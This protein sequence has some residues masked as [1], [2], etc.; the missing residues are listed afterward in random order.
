MRQRS[1][2]WTVPRSFS[3]TVHRV[4][5]QKQWL[6]WN[7]LSKHP[8]S[9]LTNLSHVTHIDFKRTAHQEF[10]IHRS[11]IPSI[12]PQTAASQ[13][14]DPVIA[15]PAWGQLPSKSAYSSLIKSSPDQSS[16]QLVN[17]TIAPTQL[18]CL[19]GLRISNTIPVNL[20]NFV[21]TV[22]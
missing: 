8:Q 6:R 15:C 9:T 12:E 11:W 18:F 4:T 19:T 21:K 22:V 1:S 14:V 3:I 10:Y 5:T 20:V 17:W 16:S 13:T 2:S 7:N